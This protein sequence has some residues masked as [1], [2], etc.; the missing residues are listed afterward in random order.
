MNNLIIYNLL[1]LD[2]KIYHYSFT[3]EVHT[4]YLSHKL[5]DYIVFLSHT[6]DINEFI[7]LT[8]IMIDKNK[9]I[10]F[11]SMNYYSYNGLSNEFGI[12]PYRYI[13]KNANNHAYE[14]QTCI[15][16]NNAIYKKG[17]KNMI[18]YTEGFEQA[19]FTSALIK[20]REI[21]SKLKIPES[22]IS[23]I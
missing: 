13:Y 7:T 23:D 5:I 22:I 19:L 15:Y 21:L 10:K 9:S 12:N 6:K 11:S 14:L 20:N 8:T 1:L 3:F 4:S 18:Y 2:N 17:Q 16:L